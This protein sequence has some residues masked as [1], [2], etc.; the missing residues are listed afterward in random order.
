MLT[1]NYSKP[2]TTGKAYYVGECLSTDNKP[3]DDTVFN[4]SKLI[5]I[6]TGKLYIYDGEGKQWVEFGG[7]S[8]A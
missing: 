3:V 6:D 2:M 1:W 4:G 7:E 5:E 8:D